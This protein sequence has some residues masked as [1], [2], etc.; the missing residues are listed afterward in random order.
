MNE[1]Y[2]MT[3]LQKGKLETYV[4]FK[5]NFVFENYLALL[6][7]EERKA[8]TR[9]R[10]SANNLPIERGRYL[11]IPRQLRTCTNCSSHQVGDEIHVLFECPKYDL[12]RQ[13]MYGRIQQHCKQFILLNNKNK[14]IWVLNCENSDVLKSLCELIKGSV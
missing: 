13:N 1:W 14:L 9:L 6:S 12:L 3:N 2:N 5:T 11:G 10:T 7:P 8:L 4:K